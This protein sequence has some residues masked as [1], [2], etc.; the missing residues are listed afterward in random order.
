MSSTAE[1][2]SSDLE[3]LILVNVLGLVICGCVTYAVRN[4]QGILIE[5]TKDRLIEEGKEKL[6]KWLND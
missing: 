5:H 4:A 3:Q 6:K 2:V 1:V